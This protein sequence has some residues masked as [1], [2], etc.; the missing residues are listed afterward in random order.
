MTYHT[1][2]N[3]PPV[4]LERFA[5]NKVLG[6]E[7][8]VLTHVGFDEKRPRIYVYIT[9]NRKPYV[10]SLL[11]DDMGF[12]RTVNRMLKEHVGT[13]IRIIGGLDM[14]QTL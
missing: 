7:I 9:H 10:G 6:G 8:G 2:R 3:W 4:W 5:D 14:S 13:P 12:C 11:F 1:I